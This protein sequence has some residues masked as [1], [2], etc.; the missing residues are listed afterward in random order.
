MMFDII[1]YILTLLASLSI[2][3]AA[4]KAGVLNSALQ[5]GFAGVST[6]VVSSNFLLSYTN[7]ESFLRA[8][9][10]GEVGL[11]GYL[12]IA[13]L[14]LLILTWVSNLYNYRQAII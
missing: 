5:R 11:V 14:S 10:E 3:G 2:V 8:C 13:S 1:I 9:L 4:G 6:Q 12:F 7:T